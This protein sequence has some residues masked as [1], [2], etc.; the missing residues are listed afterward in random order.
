MFSPG[1][2]GQTFPGLCVSLFDSQDARQN[3][4][5]VK[6]EITLVSNHPAPKTFV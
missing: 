1:S 6:E 5:T 2:P 4:F 3:Y